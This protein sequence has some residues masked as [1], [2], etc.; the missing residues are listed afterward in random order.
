MKQRCTIN[1]LD[2]S[3]AGSDPRQTILGKRSFAVHVTVADKAKRG[4]ISDHVE[5]A[6]ATGG[7]PLSDL[8]ISV[9]FQESADAIEFYKHYRGR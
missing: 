6:F 1:R 2:R 8:N 5:V 3:P 7:R 9:G 4:G